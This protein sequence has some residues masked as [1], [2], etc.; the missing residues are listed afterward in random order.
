M[1]KNLSLQIVY[2]NLAR[3]LNDPKYGVSMRKLSTELG[4][5]E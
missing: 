4:R 5:S 3:L 1:D 2:D